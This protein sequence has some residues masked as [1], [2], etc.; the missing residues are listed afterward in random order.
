MA[1]IKL[2]LI[3]NAESFLKESLS[4]AISAESNPIDWKYA[5]LH[6]IQSI[7]LTLKEKLSQSHPILIYENIDKPQNTVSLD[8]ALDRL[9]KII[10]IDFREEDLR[11]LRI[12]KEWRNLITHY[13]FSFD[14]TTVKPVF[15]QLFGLLSYFHSVQLKRELSAS[16]PSELWNEAISIKEYS[17]EL[18][19]RALKRIKDEKRKFLITC[20]RCWH[21]TFVEDNS[22]DTCYL[23][24]FHEMTTVCQE[25]G[26]GLFES[27]ALQ[28]Y[29]GKWYS[30]KDGKQVL[31]DWY[32]HLCNKCYEKFLGKKSLEE[33]DEE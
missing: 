29:Y 8:R 19:E 31:E 23:C 25:C 7:E 5:I 32:P 27:E 10:K 18:Y 22:I 26:E 17:D 12:A 20:I 9:V 21:D 33:D 16:I 15:S 11:A 3:E 2:S 6:L 4:K 1:S 14:I 28:V 30:H 24:G 13:E